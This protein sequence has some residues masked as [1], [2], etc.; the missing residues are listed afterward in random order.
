MLLQLLLVDVFAI[1]SFIVVVFGLLLLLLLLGLEM[2]V[3]AFHL[4]CR[5]VELEGNDPC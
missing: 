4:L 2:L 1:C 5:G 3:D